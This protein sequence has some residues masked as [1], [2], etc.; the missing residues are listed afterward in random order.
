MKRY[1]FNIRY[2]S[3]HY[4]NK[5]NTN[6]FNN[7]PFVLG[8]GITIGFIG[9]PKLINY[10][11]NSNNSNNEKSIMYEIKKYITR[12]ID[13]PKFKNNTELSS[14]Q[15]IT[16]GILAFVMRCIII[17]P[18]FNLLVMLPMG[19]MFFGLTVPDSKHYKKL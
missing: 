15:I 14:K 17:L 13:T 16:C 8:I 6:I 4:R 1:P 5:T 3:N 18:E 10:R 19:Y 2:R 9:L 7:V 12:Y 11:N